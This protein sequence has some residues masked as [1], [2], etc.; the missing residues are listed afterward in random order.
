MPQC[1][2]CHGTN[3]IAVQHDGYTNLEPCEACIGPVNGCAKGLSA[4]PLCASQQR[5]A[6]LRTELAIAADTE[7]IARRVRDA[8][9]QKLAS[10]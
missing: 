1:E 10:V 7:R 3:R 6:V 8:L 5:E 2:K 4:C 9:E